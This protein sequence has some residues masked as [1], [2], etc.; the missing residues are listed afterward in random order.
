MGALAVLTAAGS[1]SRLGANLPKALVEVAGTPIVVRAAQGLAEAGCSGI[2]VTAPAQ[3][4][5]EFRALLT[6]HIPGY[7][8]VK[9]IVVPGGVSRQASVAAGIAALTEVSAKE[10][11][12]EDT[13][14]GERRVVLVHDAARCLTPAEMIKRVITAVES[15][16]NAVIPALPLSDTLKKV[17]ASYDLSSG[18]GDSFSVQEV[19]DTVDRTSLA[20]VQTPQGFTL[21]T[22]RQAHDYGTERAGDEAVSATDDAALVEALGKKVHVVLGDAR[23]MKV[24]T[25]FD[26][27]V[28]EIFCAQEE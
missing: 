26:V 14:G 21:E 25:P 9:V 13:V 12:A 5:S 2:V 15:G 20:A 4:L 1:G 11:V 10:S 7:P 3:A 22:L 16:L 17:G 28:A 6:P 19:V 23:A 8:E 24:T 18:D 27:Q